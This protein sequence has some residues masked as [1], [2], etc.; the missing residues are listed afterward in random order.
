MVLSAWTPLN[1]KLFKT[2]PIRF[3]EF[4]NLTKWWTKRG[5]TITHG[6]INDLINF[7]LDVKIPIKNQKK[8]ENIDEAIKIFENSFDQIKI[9]LENLNKYPLNRYEIIYYLIRMKLE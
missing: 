4:I 3:D 9:N 7:D 8:I 1:Q 2:K 6:N 5:K